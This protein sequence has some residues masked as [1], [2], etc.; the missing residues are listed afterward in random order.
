ML[1]SLSSGYSSFN[2]ARA[3]EWAVSAWV[4][5]YIEV[6]HKNA[7]SI[8]MSNLLRLLGS[9][10]M[11]Q[12]G[13]PSPVHLKQ[14]VAV[15]KLRWKSSDVTPGKHAHVGLQKFQ[16]RCFDCSQCRPTSLL[17]T[18]CSLL[19]E[20]VKWTETAIRDTTTLARKLTVSMECR[21]QA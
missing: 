9:R 21:I 20:R 1:S 11:I 6:A 3:G 8:H 10:L 15:W 18:L 2:R 19:D 12:I 17:R 14:S 16:T 7:Y 13:C 5:K 4:H